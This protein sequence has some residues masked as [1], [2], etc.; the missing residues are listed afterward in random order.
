M[1][2]VFFGTP[3]Y[4][5]PVVE[6]IH[7]KIKVNLGSSVVAV[8][9][10]PPKPVGRKKIV[11]YSPVDG[12]AH[13]RKIPTFYKN[14]DLLEKGPEADLGILAAY[15]SIIPEAVIKRFKYG[16]LNIHPAL[17]PKF[18][19]ASPVQPA[20]ASGLPQT[21]VTIIKLDSQMDHGPI[22]S[23]FKE[24]IAADDS[25][26]T[27]RAKLFLRGAEV[28]VELIPVF[29]KGK[30]TPRA[31]NHDE[32]SYTLL[33]KRED[34]FIPPEYLAAALSGSDKIKEERSVS[35]VRDLALVPNPGNLNNFIRALYPW[36]C[37]W[38]KI[39]IRNQKLR[40]KILKAHEGDG[41]LELD[42]V[43]LEGKSPVSWDE[44]KRGY[45]DAVF[46]E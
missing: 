4:V 7:K 14:T 38:T 43:Q 10:Q 30:I 37:A 28:L 12:W 25:C 39:K 15:G 1:K 33:V 32:A 9:T 27:L 40:I 42:L 29:I 16:I 23:Q 24:E 45:A 8:V 31:Q 17:L 22:V 36:P 6:N 46:A 3:E 5:L 26:E 19:G 13:Q 20:I 2:I 41:K 34:G 18:R 11:T 35:F 44:F 21:G